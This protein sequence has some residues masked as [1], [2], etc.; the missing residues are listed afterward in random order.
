MSQEIQI[1]TSPEVKS[2]KFAKL[3][4]SLIFDVVGMLSYAVPVLAEIVDIVWAPISGLLLVKM[5]KGTTG[6]IAGIVE[7]LEELLPETDIIPTFTLTWLYVYVIKK[8]K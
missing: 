3:I 1:E 4:L 8:E 2:H 7:F 5:Y 6:K